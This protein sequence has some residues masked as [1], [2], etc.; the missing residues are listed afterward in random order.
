LLLVGRFI[1]V[2]SSRQTLLNVNKIRRTF[3]STMT[4]NASDQGPSMKNLPN[5]CQFPQSSAR[6]TIMLHINIHGS[7]SS[8][9]QRKATSHFS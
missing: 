1:V 9:P 7:G 6:A 4:S 2:T 8:P 3:G 5:G